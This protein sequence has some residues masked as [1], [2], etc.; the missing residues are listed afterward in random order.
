MSTNLLVRSANKILVFFNNTPVGLC[1]NIRFSED[2]NPD[3]A[4]GVG[5]IYAQEYVPTFANYEVSTSFMV[6]NT[7]SMYSAGIATIDG[8]QALQ[9]LVFD[10]E[11]IDAT[12]GATLR[13]YVGCTYARGEVEVDKHRI[14]LSNASF[15]CLSPTGNL[16]G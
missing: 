5:N 9:G 13:K 15:K 3:Y 1:Q 10:I 14:V 16:L 6:L 12:T 8:A 2:Y 7:Q 4:S 11:I